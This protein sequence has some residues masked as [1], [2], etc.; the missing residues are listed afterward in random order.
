MG[1]L[2]LAASPGQEIAIGRQRAG[3]VGARSVSGQG[4]GLAA[5]ASPIDLATFA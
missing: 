3:G 1:G 4:E 5:A 2:R